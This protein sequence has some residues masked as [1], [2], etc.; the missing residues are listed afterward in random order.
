[1]T[2]RSWSEKRSAGKRPRADASR[3]DQR[4]LGGVDPR[5]KQ[6]A[7]DKLAILRGYHFAL[8]KPRMP[9]TKMKVRD[10]FLADVNSGILFPHR[11]MS[12]INHIARST[13]YNWDKL[14][15]NGGLAALIPRY[16][17]KLLIGKA[18]FRPLERPMEVKLP[19]RPCA[20]GKKDLKTRIKRRWKNPPLLCPIRLSIFHSMPIPQ[21]ITMKMRMKLIRHQT[22]YI[23]KP[24]LDVLNAFVLDAMTGIVFKDRS[25]IVSLHSERQFDWWPQTR[26]LIKPLPG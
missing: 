16:G 7:Y 24:N 15:R 9:K 10:R 25:Q 8:S 3:K 21:G 6:I 2:F 1:M 17:T 13:L 4:G 26:I 12:R 20:R 23:G 14:F 5:L 11:A 18:T 22:S 19:G